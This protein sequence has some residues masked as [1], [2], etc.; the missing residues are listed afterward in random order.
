MQV[1]LSPVVFLFSTM[2]GLVF[3]Q[4]GSGT[5]LETGFACYIRS[6]VVN[7]CLVHSCLVMNASCKGFLIITSA[8]YCEC[9]GILLDALW[10]YV[11]KG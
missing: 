8:G 2:G 3:I 7:F 10:L 5:A 4:D 11:A 9:T 1:V 6:L